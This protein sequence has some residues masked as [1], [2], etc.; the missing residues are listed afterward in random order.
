MKRVRTIESN[1]YSFL[2]SKGVLESGSENDIARAK[3]EYWRIYKAKWR[4]EK[5]KT[6]KEFTTSWEKDE[7]QRLRDTAKRHKRSPTKFIKQ[8]T[9]A[10]MDKVYIV[11]DEHT[12][13]LIAQLLGMTY[14]SV[15]EMI[16]EQS[17]GFEAGKL[18]CEKIFELEREVRPLLHHPK[19][20]ED[21]IASA[22]K[23]D[24]AM[25]TRIY[26]LLETIPGH[27]AQKYQ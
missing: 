27:G 13:R 26:Y 17:V 12:V 24:P 4:R 20:L 16:A 21:W 18:L 5:R 22:I 9:V 2:D 6:A 23:S 25:K 10:Y 8:A 1:I 7:L 11:P 15:Q 3:R 14:N 19:A